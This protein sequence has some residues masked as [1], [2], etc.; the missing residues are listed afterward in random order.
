MKLDES[1]EMAKGNELKIKVTIHSFL[2][3]SI[4]MPIANSHRRYTQYDVRGL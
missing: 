4:R 1:T 2:K 3:R